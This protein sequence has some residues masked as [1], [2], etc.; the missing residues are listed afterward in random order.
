MQRNRLLVAI[1][2]GFFLALLNAE[3]E[4]ASPK[5]RMRTFLREQDEL[6]RKRAKDLGVAA[7]DSIR[8]DAVLVI[9]G[10]QVL[11]E[12]YY[13]GYHAE[14]PHRLW[15]IGKSV[16]GTIVGMAVKEGKIALA[17]SVC[18]YIP[19]PVDTRSAPFVGDHC[20]ITV[21]DV[22]RW[23]TG[24]HWTESY[25][26]LNVRSS[27]VLAMLYGEGRN[28]MPR[29][30]FDHGLRGEAGKFFLYSS[31]DTN[32]LWAILRAVYS[33]QEY[34]ALP[35]R[36]LFNRLGMENVTLERDGSGN[37][38]GASHMI[39][40]PRDLAK[41]GRFILDQKRATASEAVLPEGWMQ[42]ATTLSQSLM[43][44]PIP[45]GTERRAA[46]AQWWL[47]LPVPEQ[48]IPQPWPSG[49]NDTFAGLGVFGQTLFLVPSKDLIAIRLGHDLVGGFDRDAF[50]KEALALVDGRGA[51]DTADPGTTPPADSSPDAEMADLMKELKNTYPGTSEGQLLANYFAK[52]FCTCLFVVGQSEAI[53]RKDVKFVSF[54]ISYTVDAEK[55][56]VS[57]RNML[58]RAKG[59]WLDPKYG[60][61]IVEPEL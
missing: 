53:C 41:F 51:D 19:A 32:L 7:D 60:C 40:R 27:S 21:E 50:L 1:G 13:N 38:T 58:A 24:I 15:S 23:S 10:D 35:W 2:L 4:A 16:T 54:L 18:K 11:F 20:A 14:M 26:S 48:E 45:E 34:D 42:F 47:N 30:V 33:G 61:R 39:M 37:F 46:G 52:E 3:A 56:E 43:L 31:G 17:D 57:T 44:N 29:F 59:K 9:R 22:L 12:E 28:D 6:G 5:E 55:R 8:T 49:P 36:K 25:G